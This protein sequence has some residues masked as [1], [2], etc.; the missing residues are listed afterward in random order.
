[1]DL[2]N[3]KT[4]KEDWMTESKRNT[5]PVRIKLLFRSRGTTTDQGKIIMTVALRDRGCKW[6]A[7]RAVSTPSPTYSL[8]LLFIEGL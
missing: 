8:L 4:M 5:F 2:G 7:L 1:M 6:D 3:R